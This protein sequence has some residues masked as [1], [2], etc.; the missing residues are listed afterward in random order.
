VDP[1]A[2]KALSSAAAA[3]GKSSTAHVKDSVTTSTDN[4]AASGWGNNHSPAVKETGWE[5]LPAKGSNVSSSIKT[6]GWG[7][8][9]VEVS[10]STG[11]DVTSDSTG[12]GKPFAANQSVSDWNQTEN[13]TNKSA[14]WGASSAEGKEGSGW[15][16]LVDV[17][18]KSPGVDASTLGWSNGNQPPAVNHPSDAVGKPATAND[19][20]PRDVLLPSEKGTTD[21]SYIF[22]ERRR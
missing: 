18:I 5:T 8:T 17:E 1:S 13:P 12:W 20:A 19:P 7:E 9:D 4:A 3:W 14:G 21:L 15:G 22:D 2:L 10:K 16:R 11:G 6:T